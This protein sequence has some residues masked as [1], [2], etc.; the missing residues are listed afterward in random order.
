MGA[1]SDTKGHSLR[2][3]RSSTAS[4]GPDREAEEGSSRR[5]GPGSGTP[6]WVSQEPRSEQ[7][8]ATVCT[9]IP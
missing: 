7:T 8:G 2:S 1:G 5:W 9:C 4:W 3:S 6:H